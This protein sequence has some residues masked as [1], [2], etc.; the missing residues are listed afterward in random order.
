MSSKEVPAKSCD[1]VSQLVDEL[2]LCTRSSTPAPRA[3]DLKDAYF[4]DDEADTT[5][6][7]EQKLAAGLRLAFN[8]V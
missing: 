6:R 7:D 1:W 4:S 2:C 3:A 5:V 8:K